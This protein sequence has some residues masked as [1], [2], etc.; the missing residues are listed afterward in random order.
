[1]DPLTLAAIMGGVGLLKGELLDRPREEK[2]REMAAVT[3]RWSPWTGMAPQPIKEA[4]P[5][6]SALQS[7]AIGGMLGQKMDLTGGSGKAKDIAEV[8]GST[9]SST[10]PYLTAEEYPT[11]AP[12]A[13]QQPLTLDPMQVWPLIQSGAMAPERS[14]YSRTIRG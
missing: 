10:G 3:A 14:P 6:G 5:F 11:Q 2:Q 8:A 4:D 7:A 9:P 13:Q 1:M 12:M